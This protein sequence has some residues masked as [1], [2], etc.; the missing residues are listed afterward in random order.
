[1][2][3][4]DAADR[5]FRSARRNRDA[6]PWIELAGPSLQLRIQ[7]G[8]ARPFIGRPL[9]DR[10][11]ALRSASLAGTAAASLTAEPIEWRERGAEI[12]TA[13]LLSFEGDNAAADRLALGA[14]GRLPGEIQAAVLGPSRK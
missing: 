4:L 12:W 1:V 7:S 13:S 14:I 2:G 10:L 9:K 11:D 6:N 3:P 5:R 8:A